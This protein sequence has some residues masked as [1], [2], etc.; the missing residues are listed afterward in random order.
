ML[1]RKQ[2]R[3]DSK[4]KGCSAS[5]AGQQAEETVETAEKSKYS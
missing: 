4:M 5:E 3:Q 2:V 1:N